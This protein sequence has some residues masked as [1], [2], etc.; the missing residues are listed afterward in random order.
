MNITESQ[1]YKQDASNG[2]DV[3]SSIGTP[4]TASSQAIWPFRWASNVIFLKNR[5]LIIKS[6][7]N[8]YLK[9]RLSSPIIS[10]API[11][12]AGSY[13]IKSEINSPN[14]ACLGPIICRLSQMRRR[15][16][17]GRSY[18]FLHPVIS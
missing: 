10:F 7:I 11:I 18:I 14:Y 9:I 3:S 4:T 17:C 16:R 15:R 5:N 2:S 1:Q 13:I 12:F 8:Q 6:R